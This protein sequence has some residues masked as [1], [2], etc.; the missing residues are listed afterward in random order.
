MVIIQ[1]QLLKSANG[2]GNF[3]ARV[4]TLLQRYGS[5]ENEEFASD[6]GGEIAKTAGWVSGAIDRFKLH[7]VVAGIWD[8]IKFGDGYV[9]FHKPWKTGDKKIIAQAVLLLSAIADF[10]EP[11][12]PKAAA[13]IKEGVANKQKIDNLF[14]RLDA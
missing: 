2:L 9:D 4:S 14:P 3:A 5:A 1:K 6:I 7:E 10:A 12:V 13:K 11:I 8:L